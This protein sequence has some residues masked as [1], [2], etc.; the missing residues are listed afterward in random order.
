MTADLAHLHQSHAIL[1][2]DRLY[3]YAL[4]RANHGLLA[5]QPHYCAFCLLNPSTASETED[6]ATVRKCSGFAQRWGFNG[7]YIVNLFALRATDP[8][9]LKTARN[10]PN[11]ALNDQWILTVARAAELVVVG[12]GNHGKLYDRGLRVRAMLQAAGVPL[13]CWGFTKSGQPLHPLYLPYTQP[14]ELVPVRGVA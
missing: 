4:L 10:I 12:W 1:S 8:D 6:D 5:P 9:E 14:I 11:D 7:F 13:H 3:R 2:A